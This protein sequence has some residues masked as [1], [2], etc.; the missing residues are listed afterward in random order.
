MLEEIAGTHTGWVNRIALYCSKGANSIDPH[1]T[2]TRS[3]QEYDINNSYPLT[4]LL[5]SL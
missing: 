5:E 4:K 3:L 1:C 2:N